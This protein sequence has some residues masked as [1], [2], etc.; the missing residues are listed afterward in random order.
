MK[1]QAQHINLGDTAK[2]VLIRKPTAIK[3]YIKQQK[4]VKTTTHFC[5]LRDQEK[6][7]KLNPKLEDDG[8]NKDQRR[9]NPNRKYKT[10]RD[11]Q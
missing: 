7:N 8:D 9:E 5:S 6:E 11:N 1:I 2:A 4:D 3:H 10:I